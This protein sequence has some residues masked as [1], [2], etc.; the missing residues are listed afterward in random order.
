MLTIDTPAEF[1]LQTSAMWFSS[2]L[3]QGQGKT[4]IQLIVDPNEGDEPRNAVLDC[5]FYLPQSNRKVVE[6]VKI[7]QDAP[8]KSGIAGVPTTNSLNYPCRWEGDVL[9]VAAPEGAKVEAI[10]LEGRVLQQTVINQAS[11]SLRISRGQSALLV[12]VTVKGRAVVQKV[13]RAD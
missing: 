2:T 5:H 3:W 9:H 4:K 12:R 8:I 7:L 1:S 6:H 10:S 11:C 13:S